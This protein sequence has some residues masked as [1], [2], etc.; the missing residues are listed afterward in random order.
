MAWYER[1]A[2]Q[3]ALDKK[4]MIVLLYGAIGV[5]LVVFLAVVFK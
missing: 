3:D 5:I 1:K 4:Q 2:E